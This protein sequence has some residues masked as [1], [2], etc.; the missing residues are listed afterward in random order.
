MF[1]RKDDIRVLMTGKVYI[2]IIKNFN[3]VKKKEENEV[4][5]FFEKIIDIILW[6]LNYP[7]ISEVVKEIVSLDKML[8][9][10][11]NI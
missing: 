4:L 3:L 10:L 9:V 11:R 8:L 6:V 5:L 7:V 1:G 2:G